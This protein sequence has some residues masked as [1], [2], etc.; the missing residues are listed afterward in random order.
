MKIQYLLSVENKSSINTQLEDLSNTLGSNFKNILN[1]VLKL[2]EIKLS[3]QKSGIKFQGFMANIFNLANFFNGIKANLIID[4]ESLLLERFYNYNQ[5]LD[6]L[7]ASVREKKKCSE[8]GLKM[9][10]WMRVR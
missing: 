3:V 7:K 8:L 2:E 5:E 4:G 10:L 9:T 1:W 6:E